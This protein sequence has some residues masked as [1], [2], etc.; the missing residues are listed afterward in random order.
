VLRY[1]RPLKPRR[2]VGVRGAGGAFDVLYY[3]SSVSHNIQHGSYT[4]SFELSRNGLISSVPKVA[5]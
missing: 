5:V 1:G 3:V 2:L 4:Q